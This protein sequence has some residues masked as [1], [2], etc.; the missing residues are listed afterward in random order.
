MDNRKHL[1]APCK[2]PP[3]GFATMKPLP[4]DVPESAKGAKTIKVLL[5][6]LATVIQGFAEIRS[7]YGTGPGRNGKVRGVTSR[8]ASLAVGAAS[9][10]VTFAFL[11]HLDNP[12]EA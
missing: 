11:T 9:A 7:L 6:N 3:E 4:D 12:A 10:L 5:S 1:I 8:H 2:T